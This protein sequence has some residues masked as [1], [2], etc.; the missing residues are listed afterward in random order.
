MR[1]NIR[2]SVAPQVGLSVEPITRKP[3]RP[4]GTHLRPS[5]E[6]VAPLPRTLSARRGLEFYGWL[7]LQRCRASG[8][9]SRA[10]RGCVADAL[11]GF[12]RRPTGRKFARRRRREA[13][14]SVYFYRRGAER[15]SHGRPPQRVLGFGWGLRRGQPGSKGD[16]CTEPLLLR[17][18]ASASSRDASWF[19]RPN[20]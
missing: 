20:R 18:A 4:S 16:S 17:F 1:G 9:E 8:A 14:K 6:P 19:A 15:G 11:A 3:S 7:V 5:T 2:E 10:L 13:S 12:I